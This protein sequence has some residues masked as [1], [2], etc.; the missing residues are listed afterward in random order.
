ML[1]YLVIPTFTFF[2]CNCTRPDNTPETLK[3]AYSSEFYIGTALSVEQLSGKDSKSLE[4][5]K[6]HFNSIVAEN[7]MKSAEIRPVNGE[8]FFNQADKFVEFG[9]KNNMLIIGH[10]LIWHSQAPDWF[11]ID[12][13]G[14]QVS[15]EVL[16][17]RMRTHIHTTVGRYK[18][19]IHGWDVVNEAVEDDGSLRKSKFLEIIGEDYVK[20]AFQFAHE[21]DPD[22]ELYYNDYSMDKEPKRNGVIKLVQSIKDAGLRIDA[23]GMQGHVGLNYPDLNEFEKSLV[24]FSKLNLNVMITELDITVLPSPWEQTGAEISTNFEYQEKMNPYKN[25]LPAEVEAK[26]AMR[27][28]DFFELFNKHSEKI[29]RV[30]L[31]GVTDKQTWRNDWPIKG[32]TDY[33]LPFDRNYAA[34]SFVKDIIKLTKK[35]NK[36]TRFFK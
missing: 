19:R 26:L 4:I 16:I 5:A 36:Q 32:R 31:W 18:R 33:P 9:E 1:K 10:T 14:N 22:A 2:F 11:F 24:A 35:N 8:F 27:Y 12:D 7:C 29:T 34:K 17:E 13:K 6:K 23:V 15:R 30:T 28:V 21:A 25:E 20:L 3:D